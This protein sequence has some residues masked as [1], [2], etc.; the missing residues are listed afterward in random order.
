M[1]KQDFLTELS[2]ALQ[3]LPQS[4]IDK[5]LEY[6]SEIIYDQMEEGQTEE[7]AVAALDSPNNIANQI[8]MDTALPK[9]V[10]A[11]VKPARTMRIGEI[12]LLVLGSPIWA[13]LLFAGVVLLFSLYITV[14]SV[15]ITLYAVNLSFAVGA[16]IGIIQGCIFIFTGDPA[17]AAFYIGAAFACFGAAVL[18]FFAF[19][20]IT[21]LLIHA[22]KQFILWIKSL[23]LRRNTAKQKNT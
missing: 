6:Y 18:S 20:K 19:N 17:G 8:L 3:G 11:K 9:L 4:D 12:L 13:S 1:N 2:N 16:L 7:E 5:S 10:R 23:F 21:A 22:T 15:I 14:W